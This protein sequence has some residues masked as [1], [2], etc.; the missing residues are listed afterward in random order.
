ML[1][2]NTECEYE[3]KP[4]ENISLYTSNKTQYNVFSQ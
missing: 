4:I 3:S 1:E 2:L